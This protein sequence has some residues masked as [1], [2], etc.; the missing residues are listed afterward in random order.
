MI[1]YLAADGFVTE[2]LAELGEVSAVHGRLVIAPGPRRPAAWAA[3]VWL[4]PERIAITSINDGRKA[5]R[6]RSR[7]WALYS[8]HLHRRAQLINE[9]WQHSRQEFPFPAT[10]PR[11]LI[12]GWTLL[13]EKTILAATQRSCPFPL[14]EINFAENHTEPPSRAYLKLWELFSRLQVWPKAGERCLDLGASPG[15]WTWVLQGL[16]AHVVAVDKAPLAPRVAKLVECRQESAFGLKPEPT[17]WLF[18]DVI[19]EP[20]RLLK[21]VERWLPVAANI[22][23]TLKFKGATDHT[24]TRAFAAIPGSRLLHLH[25]NRHEL[26]WCRLAAI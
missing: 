10:P 23:C 14:G 1:A 19:C 8:F 21:L 15:G 6:A 17:D 7:Q 9:P 2:L 16:G 24:T 11:A 12:G 4:N 3:D 18:S 26:T 22:V 20:A 25:H 5:L 13:D